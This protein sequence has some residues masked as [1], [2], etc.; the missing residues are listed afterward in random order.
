MSHTVAQTPPFGWSARARA[1]SWAAR[2]AWATPPVCLLSSELLTYRGFEN[3]HRSLSSNGSGCSSGL[4]QTNLYFSAFT[5]F[6]V[7]QGGA[8]RGGAGLG[9]VGRKLFC[10]I[11]LV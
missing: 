8:G 7:G 6:R 10:R 9:G 4:R 11:G 1:A 3:N 2:Q 5:S